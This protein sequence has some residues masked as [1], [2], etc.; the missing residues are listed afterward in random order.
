[1]RDGGAAVDWDRLADVVH[2]G[3]RFL[4]DVI[5][6]NKY[7][8]DKIGEL[9]HGNRKIGLGVMGWADMLIK[10]G[11]A[12]DSEEAVSLGEKIMGFIDAEAH[13]GLRKLAEERGVF[14]NFEGSIYDMPDGGPIRNATV[15]TIAPTG[16]LS[17]IANCQQRRSSRSSR[18]RYVRTVMD[19]DRLIEVNPIFE[20]VAIKQGFYSRELMG[21]HRRARFG[22]RHRG[23]A[24]GRAARLRDRARH[25]AGL[26]REAM[27]AAFQ[28]Y[29]DNAVSKTVNFGNDAT[30]GRRPRRYTTWPTSWASRA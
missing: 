2:R 30:A 18:S 15:T 10:M 16:T 6:V 25:R 29:T 17:I 8:L 4:D 28:K 9:A 26:A 5:D 7:P 14:P 21:A 27:Q 20:D 12:Y 1:M 23:G 22:A 11:I 13:V 19:N 24:G 3:V